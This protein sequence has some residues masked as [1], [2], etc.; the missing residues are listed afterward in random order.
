MATY[1]IAKHTWNDVSKK[2]NRIARKCE[3]YGAPFTVEKV[4]EE[5]RKVEND[6]SAINVRFVLVE[7]EGACKCGDWQAVA[8]LDM[9]NSGN[10][11]RMIDTHA[12]IP[13][14]YRNSPNI[15][16]H[17]GTSRPR[18]NLYVIRNN[19]NGEYKQVGGTCLKDY[20]GLDLS[21]VVAWRDG[22]GMLEDN[23]GVISGDSSNWKKCETVEQI[24]AAACVM[25]DTIGYRNANYYDG[26]T[27]KNAICTAIFGAGFDYLRKFHGIDINA[28]DITSD[29]TKARAAAIIDYYKNLDDN[30]DFIHNV[31]TILNDGYAEQ[32]DLGYLGY[33]PT[34][35][36]KANERKKENDNDIKEFDYFGE[37]GKRYKDI[38]INAARCVTSWEGAYGVT[39]VYKIEIDGAVLI[40]KTTKELDTDQINRITFTVKAHNEYNGVKQ[41]E[42]TRCKVA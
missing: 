38:T 42:V 27:T 35:Y 12:T 21:A 11:V 4:G 13:D 32:R 20:C 9:R 6:G 26:I 18:K 7:V 3:R 30:S 24:I 15:C 16:D 28:T 29:E 19:Q 2:L 14:Y 36:A 22:L 33:L 37:I 41:T 10:I 8:Q 17:C 39:H 40:W 5:V 23:D 25:T 1:A 31:K 34:G